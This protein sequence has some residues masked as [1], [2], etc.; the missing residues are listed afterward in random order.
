MS[1]FLL[2]DAYVTVH[3]DDAADVYYGGVFVPHSRNPLQWAGRL[4]V[5]T[6]GLPYVVGTT[7]SLGA[8]QPRFARDICF[9]L[10][11]PPPPPR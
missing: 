8:P 1:G 6:V 3:V 9:A 7:L 11:H 10:K 5:A 4:D 2:R